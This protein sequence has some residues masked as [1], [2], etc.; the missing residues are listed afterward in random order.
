MIS[1][2]EQIWQVAQSS[3]KKTAIIIGKEIISYEQLF[4]RF[5]SAR[6]FLL[7]RLTLGDTMVLAA[8]NQVEFVY[9]YFGAHLAGIRVIPIDPKTNSL[10]L[11]YILNETKAKLVLGFETE[12]LPCIPLKE[13]YY[14]SDCAFQIPQ[15]PDMEDI[16]DILFTTGTTGLPKGV[17]LTFRNE[18][19]A[20]Q[21]INTFIGNT[22]RDIELLALPVSHSFGLGR[23]RCCLS[24]GA[25]IVLL[26]GFANVKKLYRTI[27]EQKVTGFS[28]VPASWRY[29]YKFSG[30]KLGEYA[31]QLRYI[32][33]GSAYLSSEEKMQLAEL[34]PETRICMH[35]G[36][37][38]AS[39]S[40]FLEFHQDAMHIDSVGKPSPNTGIEIFDEQGNCMSNN[41]EGELCVKGNHVMK[42]YLNHQITAD[43]FNDYFRTGDWGYKDTDGYVYLKSRKKELINVGGKKVSPFEVEEL[44]KQVE[45][46][47]DCACVGAADPEGILGEVV[48]AYVVRNPQT[49]VTFDSISS[50]LHSR[51]ES[52]KL[53]AIF[54]WTKEI[55]KTPNGKIQRY[56]LS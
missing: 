54:Q 48:K 43:F 15:F 29:L 5:L 41:M 30:N 39:R 34:L 18:A 49:N 21:N 11:H 2:E 56:L 52:Y 36:L 51:L 23:L 31:S 16:A 20:A 4:C 46:I 3:P 38:E 50:F 6:D 17:P 44:I 12:E 24:Q 22:Y 55:P 10:R 26:G 14:L 13:M 8:G 7:E 45:G 28:M 19:A 9:V 1:I 35:Y 27:E 32:E 47:V 33:M 40:A 42:G 25:T 37:T 53:P